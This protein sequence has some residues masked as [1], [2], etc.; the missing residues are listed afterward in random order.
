MIVLTDPPDPEPELRDHWVCPECG[1]GLCVPTGERPTLATEH[2]GVPY[3]LEATGLD[4]F[5]EDP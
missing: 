1:C 2:C 5:A 4:C 3:V